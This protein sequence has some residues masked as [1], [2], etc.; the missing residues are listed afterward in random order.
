MTITIHII[1]VLITINKNE[2]YEKTEIY[3]IS[4]LDQSKYYNGSTKNSS[5]EISNVYLTTKVE[6]A[7]DFSIVPLEDTLKDIIK[8]L[9]CNKAYIDRGKGYLIN[10]I[11][12]IIKDKYSVI[13]V[14]IIKNTKTYTVCD[15]KNNFDTV[16]SVKDEIISED[17]YFFILDVMV[18]VTSESSSRWEH[19]YF[20]QTVH[21]LLLKDSQPI[22]DLPKYYDN[23]MENLSLDNNILLFTQSIEKAMRFQK[24]FGNE[25]IA[26]H[27]IENFNKYI[28]KHIKGECMKI[29][30][31]ER[32][33]NNKYELLNT[34][35]LYESDI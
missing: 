30:C 21:D 4:S 12:D 24:S 35:K 28:K 27:L 14:D 25:D 1:K 5:T 18:Q 15:L 34:C 29:I 7:K 33:L 26:K 19:Y 23:S 8:C 31:S 32:M 9:K 16:L 17:K 6:N 2:E 13:E 3:Y 22:N 20:A 11:E 10:N